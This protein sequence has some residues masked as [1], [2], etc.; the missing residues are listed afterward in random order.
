MSAEPSFPI[1]TTIAGD[2]LDRLTK[3]KDG[4]W[5]V[6]TNSY[7]ALAVKVRDQDATE[8]YIPIGALKAMERGQAGEQLSF[9][10]WRV[11]TEPYAI[12][13]FDIGDVVSGAT[14]FPVESVEG[15]LW[16]DVPKS[17]F[18][19]EVAVGLNPDFLKAIDIAFGHGR[20]G[21]SCRLDM[22][23]PL[24]PIRVTSTRP[25]IEAVAALMPVRLNA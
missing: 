2:A 16:G 19:G 7:L 17:E 9:T 14:P 20:Y 24:R 21:P 12:T 3:R 6:T 25:D 23:A 11:Q 15:H 22:T 18:N 1:A 10:A 5:L 4:M 13:T 8:G